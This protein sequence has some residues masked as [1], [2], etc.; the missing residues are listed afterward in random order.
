MKEGII[1]CAELVSDMISYSTDKL[2]LEFLLSHEG[3]LASIVQWGFW[4]EHWPAMVKLLGAEKCAE[5]MLL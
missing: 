3:L 5:I 1:E 2:V 4:D